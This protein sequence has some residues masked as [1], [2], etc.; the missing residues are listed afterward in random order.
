MLNAEEHYKWKHI[1][2]SILVKHTFGIL[3]HRFKYLDCNDGQMLHSLIEVCQI[4]KVYC[5]PHNLALTTG[6]LHAKSSNFVGVFATLPD[7]HNDSQH[8]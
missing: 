2:T 6:L 5:I 8:K 3:K 7:L 4:V 1:Y